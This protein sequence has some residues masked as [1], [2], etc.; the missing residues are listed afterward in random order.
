MTN[1][2]KQSCSTDNLVQFR[3]LLEDLSAHFCRANEG[4]RQKL[5]DFIENWKHSRR[6]NHPRKSCSVTVDYAL[7]DRV[8]TSM[9]R[10]IGAGGAFIDNA[11]S[12]ATGQQTTLAFWFPTLPRPTKIKGEIAWKSS[13]GFGVKFATSPYTEAGLEKAIERF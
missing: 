5:L 2:A 8:F 1:S 13:H 7:G 6:R 3:G 9:I 12:V 4:Q 11:N 10:N